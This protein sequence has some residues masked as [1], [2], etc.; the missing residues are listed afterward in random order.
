MREHPMAGHSPDLVII[1]VTHRH[2]L[3]MPRTDV[4]LQCKECGEI[5]SYTVRGQLN[6]EDIRSDCE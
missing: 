6:I 1:A 5:T 4:I 3:W 2:W